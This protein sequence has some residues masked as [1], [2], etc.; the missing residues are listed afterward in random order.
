MK[1][2]AKLIGQFRFKGNSTVWLGTILKCFSELIMLRIVLLC[3]FGLPLITQ[4][5]LQVLA[6]S[7]PEIIFGW[8]SGFVAFIL[9]LT[10][11]KHSA[12]EMVCLHF[13]WNDASDSV[14]YIQFQT[15]SWVNSRTFSR[16]SWFF[17]ILSGLTSCNGGFLKLCMLH[18]LV[19]APCC[20]S[21][22]LF[23]C[24]QSFIPCNLEIK[25]VV[26]LLI[27]GIYLSIL[28]W[29]AISFSRG[30]S[31]PRDQTHVSRIAGRRFNLWATGE[32]YI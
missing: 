6:V 27:K 26:Y 2:F 22:T 19:L 9:E 17:I 1:I 18:L 5:S 14:K 3:A 21:Q 29:V 4:L 10:K 16:G 8:P 7:V 32:A 11:I 30:S 31:W 20:V 28:E 15:S 24:C 12:L 25:N 23:P 13:Y